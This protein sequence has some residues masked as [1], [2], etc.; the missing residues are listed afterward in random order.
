MAHV[1]KDMTFGELLA[2][3]YEKCPKK[4]EWAVSGVRILRWSRSNRERWDTVWTQISWW[5]SLMRQLVL[6]WENKVNKKVLR[7]KF[8]EALF[9]ELLN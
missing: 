7:I 1:S 5:R 6:H 2:A 4:Q 9:L 3:Y 8:S